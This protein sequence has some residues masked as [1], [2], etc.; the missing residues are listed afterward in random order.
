[1]NIRGDSSSYGNDWGLYPVSGGGLGGREEEE[2]EEV[3]VVGAG[4]GPT[5]TVD[6]G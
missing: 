3:A 5:A 1:M 6:R 4:G 2:E